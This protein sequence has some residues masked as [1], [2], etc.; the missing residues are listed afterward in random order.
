MAECVAPA[1]GRVK[2]LARIDLVQGAMV[3]GTCLSCVCV[4][5]PAPHFPANWSLNLPPLGK[6]QEYEGQE[7]EGQENEDSKS[8]ERN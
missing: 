3:T 1:V 4:N 2:Q 7:Y 5:I 6:W 8:Q